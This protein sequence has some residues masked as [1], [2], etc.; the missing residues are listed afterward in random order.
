M[1][2][3]QNEGGSGTL[4]FGVIANHK[5]ATCVAVLSFEDYLGYK[6]GLLR[7]ARPVCRTLLPNP[8]PPRY[9]YLQQHSLKEVGPL[10]AEAEIEKNQ[11]TCAPSRPTSNSC[12]RSWWLVCLAGSSVL[13]LLVPLPPTQAARPMTENPNSEKSACSPISNQEPQ[14]P[15]L[16]V[17]S[18]EY[19]IMIPI[20]A[21]YIP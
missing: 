20:T 15:I 2:N 6:I 12:F 19:R 4:D 17:V 21:Q 5:G 10:R 13:Q 3:S 16:L 1:G 7:V 8:D 14:R 11:Q 18:R 9:N